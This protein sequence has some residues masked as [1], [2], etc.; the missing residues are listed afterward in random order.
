MRS[1]KVGEASGS[2][3]C[4]AGVRDCTGGMPIHPPQPSRGPA[5]PSRR[6]DGTLRSADESHGRRE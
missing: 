6:A 5:E 2:Q 1:S 4:S 3:R